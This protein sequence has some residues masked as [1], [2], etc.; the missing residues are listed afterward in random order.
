MQWPGATTF[1]TQGRWMNIYVGDGLKYEQKTF[2]P[3]FPPVIRED[4]VEKPC[5]YEVIIFSYNFI[6]KPSRLH[7]R[8]G[9]K[10]KAGRGS[11]RAMNIMQLLTALTYYMHF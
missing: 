10:A 4:P 7:P 6:A 8:H 5:Y 1:F 3:I 11:R 9:R 2:Y